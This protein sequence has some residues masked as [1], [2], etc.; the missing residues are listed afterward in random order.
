[1]FRL[2]DGK[3]FSRLVINCFG[4]TLGYIT[5]SE[6]GE[7][8]FK[9]LNCET[10]LHKLVLAGLSESSSSKEIAYWMQEHLTV[11][12]NRA[13]RSSFYQE[14]CRTLEDEI[15]TVNSFVDCPA[16]S[17]HYD[18]QQTGTISNSSYLGAQTKWVGKASAWLKKDYVG[19][20]AI[21][22]TLVS[23]FLTSCLNVQELEAGYVGYCVFCPQDDTCLSRSFLKEGESFIPL[24]D[25]IRALKPKEKE[26]MDFEGKLEYIDSVYKGVLGYSCKRWLLKVL[27]LDV[28]FRNTDRHLS[29][30]GFIA[31]RQGNF[32]IAP[33]FDNGL[34]LGVSEGAYYDLANTITGIGFR[35]KPYGL[36]VG[37][38]EKYINPSY[39][40]FSIVK[41][42][43]YL[44]M[45]NFP[46]S[47]LQNK[48]LLAFFNILVRYYPKDALGADTKQE[49]EKHFGPFTT[50]RFIYR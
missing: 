25:A 11:S 47:E 4:T 32:R 19:G 12:Q 48:L 50:K 43:K 16:R 29:N 6:K 49:L 5:K 46:K 37:Y 1:M 28:M 36:T 35:I 7:Y 31:D 45:E 2:S 10:M 39:F 40:A 18:S 24:Y 14:G 8:S 15:Y 42:V 20:E 34:A 23:L 9:L 3:E 33:I 30:L 41:L 26:F 38:L 17:W 22:E 44:K 27:T 21:T 13:N